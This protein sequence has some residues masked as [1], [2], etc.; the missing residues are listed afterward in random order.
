MKPLTADDTDK[1]K[2]AAKSPASSRH[3][4][5]LLTLEELHKARDAEKLKSKSSKESDELRRS[6][7]AEKVK[8]KSSKES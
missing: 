7:D 6:K 2:S 4:P 3:V 5:N 8:A 1:T